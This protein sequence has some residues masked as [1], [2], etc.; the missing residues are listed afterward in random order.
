MRAIAAL[1]GLLLNTAGIGSAP[2]YAGFNA[3]YVTPYLYSGTLE[4]CIKGGK[5]ALEKHGYAI[6]NVVEF[7]DGKGSVIYSSHKSLALGATIVC[8][9]ANG[10]GS[11]S[12]AGPNDKDAF[13]S[14][15]KLLKESW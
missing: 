14:F 15:S 2:A 11:V 12:V 3:P 1:G 8:D 10:L 6:E 5:S 4:G 13:E 7:D 9:P